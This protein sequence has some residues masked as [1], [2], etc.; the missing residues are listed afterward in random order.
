MTSTKKPKRNPVKLV[1]AG[2]YSEFQF[3]FPILEKHIIYV[4][5]I[6]QLYGLEDCQFI[7]VGQWW[8]QRRELIDAFEI[9]EKEHHIRKAKP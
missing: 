8:N 5:G 7:R 9:F 3:Y 2:N 4:T 6:E 1:L